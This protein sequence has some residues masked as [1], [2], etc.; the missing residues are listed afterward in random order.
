MIGFDDKRV[1]LIHGE[2]LAR[3][4]ALAAEAEHALHETYFLANPE[5]YSWP[6]VGRI[7]S[8]ILQKRAISIR[9][10]HAVVYC[11]AAVAQLISAVQGK[12]ATLNI[13]KA[14]D[15]T[16]RYWICDVTKAQKEIGFVNQFSLEKGFE[17]T[18]QW[19]RRQG[20]L[21]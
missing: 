1:S 16:R 3:G 19:Y 13:E 8:Q 4:I 12:A 20:W 14:R 18:A 11:V 7:T 6:Q 10:P 2:D 21:R 17:Q 9:V 5:Y 15:I